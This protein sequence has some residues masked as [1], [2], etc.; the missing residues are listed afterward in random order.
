MKAYKRRTSIG[1]SAKQALGGALCSA[2]IVLLGSSVV[3]TASAESEIEE[4]VVYAQKRAQDI[5]DVPIAVTA[6]SGAQIEEASIKDVFD[7]QQQ[8]PGLRVDASQNSS[9][10]NF[11][12]RGIGTSANNF[13]LESSVG[14]YVD[15]VYRSRQ[16]ALI[17]N[18]VDIEAVEVLRG[19]QGTLFGKNTPSGAVSVRTVKPSH[20]G[21]NG[22]ISVTAG[23]YGL[24][25]TAGASNFVLSDTLAGRA[26]FFTGYR[27]GFVDVVNKGENLVNDRNRFGGRLQFL[28][29]PSDNLDIRIIADYAE[30][31]EICCAAGNFK[32]N[33]FSPASGEFGTDAALL[34]LG[35]TIIPD[36]AYDDYEIA[37][38]DLPI[39]TNE[40]K[41]ISAEINYD[42]D[43]GITF[44]SITSAR[45]F[46]SYDR[47]DA[48][49]SNVD[50]LTKENLGQIDAFTQEFRFT[51]TIG[52]NT[53][54]V[55]GAYYFSQDFESRSQLYG[56][57]MLDTYFGLIAE[58][59]DPNIPPLLDALEQVHLAC[60]Y[61][62]QGQALC[63]LIGLANAPQA[64]AFF[65]PGFLANE[66][67]V[68]DHSSWAGFAQFDFDLN[69]TTT[70]SVGLRYT[71][72]QKD[73]DGR[74]FETVDGPPPDIDQLG[75]NLYWFSQL[76]T[77]GIDPVTFLTLWQT[78]QL[79]VPYDPTAFQ[80]VWS[81]GWVGWFLDVA[82]P[83]PNTLVGLD[84]D[85]ISG[86][87]KL[88]WR[89]S[90]NVMYY[91]SYG[92]GFKSGGTN[93]DRINAAFESVFRSEHADTYEIGMKS[94]WPE[95]NLTM[96]IAG[97]YSKVDDLQNNVFTGLGFN[98][99]NAG[100][101]TSTGGEFEMLWR[102]TDNFSMA[103]NYARTV[104]EFDS[105]PRATCWTA[106][107]WHT[108]IPD[109]GDNG[110]GSCSRSGD[111][112]G[113]PKDELTVTMTRDFNL[114]GAE[115][116]VRADYLLYTDSLMDGNNDPFKKQDSVSFIN[117]HFGIHL[118]SIDTDIT[119]WGRNITDERYQRIIFDVPLQAGRL[120]SYPAEPRTVGITIRK[121]FN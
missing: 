119:L 114:A 97:Y 41:G 19:P 116:F 55:A 11:T 1:T 67:M 120:A 62:P 83:R 58:G 29:T 32:S 113:G 101:A 3:T 8:A 103:M 106:Y 86:S 23:D 75:Y 74:Y 14:L 5:Q 111:P 99:Q 108:G 82:R 79:P 44:T 70:L 15:G 40:D 68:Q 42:M 90:D 72:E 76:A 50:L 121:A 105:F 96:N 94:Q 26:T 10:S 33:L 98:L 104:A 30:I 92:E 81:D 117:M 71:D 22:F 16:A 43:N 7:L 53:N 60:N 21:R 93:T 34:G 49:F 59:F 28:F 73:L 109:P 17:N 52:D 65:G 38:N 69:D 20:D 27:D 61:T 100:T 6:L 88:A 91:A 107:T 31:D 112:L 25:N 78:G 84:D 4:I 37:L 57:P 64:G 9:T 80:S 2:A 18:L 51:G 48:D 13:G 35:G 118:D 102:P 115:A 89:A 85:R 95:K 24:L 77:G 12:I 54:F 45:S 110:D 47:I 36:D 39:S 66:V 56:E 63:P 46:E 87:I